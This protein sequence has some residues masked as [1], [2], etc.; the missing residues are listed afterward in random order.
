MSRTDDHYYD[1]YMDEEGN[2]HG[3]NGCLII[4]AVF[5]LIFLSGYW[6]STKFVGLFFK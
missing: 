6:I 3:P 4:L 1:A 5:L 2:Y